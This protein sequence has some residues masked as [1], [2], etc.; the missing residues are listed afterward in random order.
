MKVRGT[1]LHP[2]QVQEAMAGVPVSRYRFVIGREEHEG[3]LPDEGDR[4]GPLVD[5]RDWS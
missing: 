4:A 1:F 2:Q 5:T 3:T